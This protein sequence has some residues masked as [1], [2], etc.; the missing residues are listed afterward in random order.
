MILLLENR[1]CGAFLRFV[2]LPL[3][4]NDTKEPRG[5][6]ALILGVGLALILLVVGLVFEKA[7]SHQAELTKHF[8]QCMERAPFKTSLNVARPESVLSVDALQRHF[9]Q[10]DQLAKET[11]LPPIWNGTTLVPW[12]VFHQDSIEVARQCHAQLGIDQPQ[13]QLR[14]TYAKPVWDPNS[15]IWATR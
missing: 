5:H 13:R 14:G 12:T 10:F 2:T 11:G 7:W 1:S 6:L 8:E 3:P 15:S 4:M 9:E